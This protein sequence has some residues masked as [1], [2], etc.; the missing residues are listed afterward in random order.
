[1]YMSNSMRS[2]IMSIFSWRVGE[3][4]WSLFK[5]FREV[6]VG[7]FDGAFCWVSKQVVHG[8]LS[9]IPNES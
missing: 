5:S 4:Q 9:Y 6:I 2:I 7:G 8:G 3:S 1:M